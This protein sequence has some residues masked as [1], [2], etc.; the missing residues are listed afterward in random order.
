[1]G[2]ESGFSSPLACHRCRNKTNNA[3]VY[4]ALCYLISHPHQP[5]AEVAMATPIVKNPRFRK[6]MLLKAAW[7]E[8]GLVEIWTQPAFFPTHCSQS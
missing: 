8:G 4:Q 6:V 3:S 5:F 7:L 2:L 1:M